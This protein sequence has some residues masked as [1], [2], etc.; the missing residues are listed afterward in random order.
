MGFNNVQH[1]ISQNWH[2]SWIFTGASACFPS[3]PLYQTYRATVIHKEIR[4]QTVCRNI[5]KTSV[6]YAMDLSTLLSGNGNGTGIGSLP[7]RY[8]PTPTAN[9]STLWQDIPAVRESGVLEKLTPEQCK[10]QEVSGEERDAAV[11]KINEPR[12]SERCSVNLHIP[13]QSDHEMFSYKVNSPSMRHS[14][15]QYNMNSLHLEFMKAFSFPT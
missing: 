14:L 3:E 15:Q 5:S 7:P 13:S 2:K 6:D 12:G 9:Q 8:S 4:R 1:Y 10:Y 11:Q